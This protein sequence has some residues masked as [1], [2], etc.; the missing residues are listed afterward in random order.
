MTDDYISAKQAAAFDDF[1][2]NEIGVPSA[3]LMERAAL[4]VYQR[5]LAG[6]VFDLKKVLVVAGS[7]NNG[8]DGIAVARML[9]LRGLDV[10]IWL[11]GK[12]QNTS[13][14]NKRQLDIAKKIWCQN[15]FAS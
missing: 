5:L 14:E 3:V 2:I 7:G 11:L 9:F 6:R 1:T 8:G 12:R 15:P 13:P 10:T 4:A